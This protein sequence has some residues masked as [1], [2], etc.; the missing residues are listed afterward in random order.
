MLTA[1]TTTAE[2]EDEIFQEIRQ[3]LESFNSTGKEIGVQ[4]DILQD[5]TVDS[6]AV[7]NFIMT[8]ED[9]F[10]ISIPL[11][12]LPGI[13]TVGDLVTTIHRTATEV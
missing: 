9:K 11:N 6:L 8:L 12:V 13:R 10:D 4:T 7:M 1:T 2:F 3:L 5:L